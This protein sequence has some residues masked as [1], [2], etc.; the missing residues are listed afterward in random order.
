[1]GR[2]EG[3]SDVFCDFRERITPRPTLPPT[4]AIPHSPDLS[5]Q[6]AWRDDVPFSTGRNAFDMAWKVHLHDQGG[7]VFL[8][9]GAAVNVLV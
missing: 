9:E 5:L 1:M 6:R 4:S 7:E 2:G 3:G 8:Y